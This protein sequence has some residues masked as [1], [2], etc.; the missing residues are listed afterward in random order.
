LLLI[1]GSLKALD[2]TSG[3]ASGSGSV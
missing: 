3:H 2:V 1:T